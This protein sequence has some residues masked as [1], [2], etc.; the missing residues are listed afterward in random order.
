[1][2][3]VSRR[4]S[5]RR[6]VGTAVLG[7]LLAATGLAGGTAQVLRMAADP[8]PPAPRQPA[9]TT[10]AAPPATDVAP[11]VA[12]DPTA[13]VRRPR[14]GEPSDFPGSLGSTPPEALAAYQRAAA[15]LDAA[16]ACGLDWT[17]LAAIGR[18]ES[19]HG[20]GPAV[21]KPLDGRVGRGQVADTD[22]G[23]L[24]GDPRWDAPVGP[25]RLLPTTWTSVAVDADADGVRDPRDID[26]AALA[27]AVRLCAGQDLSTRRGLR[28]SLAAY[29]S[30]P[31]FVRTVLRL[32][33][34]YE[35][36][37]AQVPVVPLPSPLPVLPDD[38][39]CTQARLVHAPLEEL[40][41]TAPTTSPTTS[42]IKPP[43]PTLMPTEA[44]SHQPTDEPTSEPTTEPTSQPTGEPTSQPTDPTSTTT[45]EQP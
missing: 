42:P 12:V 27:A 25:L 23:V 34:R 20:R 18:V 10:Q 2:D 44:A 29:H 28:A 45:P 33:H 15:V 43:V 41:T 32:A 21:G 40:A 6:R 26:D 7:V 14:V 31:G 1:V 24:D 22:G 17:V 38:C 8:A 39:G 30:A 13:A 36:Q 19:D 35:R 3:A 11:A 16:G 9:S 37:S 4:G 5:R